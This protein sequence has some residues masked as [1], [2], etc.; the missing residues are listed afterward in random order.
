MNL[1]EITEN[2]NTRHNPK[3]EYNGEIDPS[4]ANIEG[5]P[6]S[7][8]VN[9]AD[10]TSSNTITFLIS[11]QDDDGIA[12]EVDLGTPQVSSHDD[13]EEPS[14]HGPGGYGDVQ[15]SRGQTK[16]TKLL[17]ND[18]NNQVLNQLEPHIT[19]QLNTL[20]VDQTNIHKLFNTVISKLNS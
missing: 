8:Y 9:E 4:I 12:W 2:L 15:W 19:D 10:S 6:Y 20:E 3:F 16:K 13:Y 18:T 5:T 7:M 14:D 11:S 1:H 17:F